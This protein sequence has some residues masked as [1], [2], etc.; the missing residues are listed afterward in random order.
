MLSFPSEYVPAPPSPN[1]TFDS[2]LRIESDI[3][4]FR[5]VDTINKR[6]S[7][8]LLLG[9]LIGLPCTAG[10]FL[11]ANEILLLFKKLD[12]FVKVYPRLI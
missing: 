1:C 9:L 12:I 7:F 2:G 11:Y 3:N 8:S 4:L 10:M 6:I 5:F